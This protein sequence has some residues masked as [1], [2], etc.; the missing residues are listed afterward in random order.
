LEE[1]FTTS[2]RAAFVVC[3]VIA[4]IGIATS[5]VRGKEAR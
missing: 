3:A 5:L 1:T 4:A 2:F